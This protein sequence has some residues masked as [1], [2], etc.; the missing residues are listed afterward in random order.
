M[1]SLTDKIKTPSNVLLI[2]TI[3]SEL[4]VKSFNIDI[5]KSSED[6]SC[7]IPIRVSHTGVYP[8]MAKLLTRLCPNLLSAR[9][10]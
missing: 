8:A 10:V 5:T 4:I 6:L 2:A 9:A 1:N 7:V 3:Y